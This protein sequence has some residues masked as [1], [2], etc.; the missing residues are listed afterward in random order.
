MLPKSGTASLLFSPFADPSNEME[1]GWRV[2][3]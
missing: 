3:G 1:I 2:G